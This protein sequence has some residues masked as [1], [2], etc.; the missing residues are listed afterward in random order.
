MLRRTADILTN[1]LPPKTEC[2][3]FVQPTALQLAVFKKILR[4]DHVQDL[5]HGPTARSLAL[6][7]TLTKICN[8][9]IMLAKSD[10]STGDDGKTTRGL[11]QEALGLLPPGASP[12]DVTLSGTFR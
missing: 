12:D 10:K 5:V 9:P 8:S 4:P 1:Y 11:V 3:V 7:T 6:I 2:V